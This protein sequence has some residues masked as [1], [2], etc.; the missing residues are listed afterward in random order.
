M[1]ETPLAVANSILERAELEG[2]R[3]THLQLQKLVYFVYKRLLQN[4]GEVLFSDFFEAWTWGPVVRKVYDCFKEYGDRNIDGY[5]YI[6]G[7]SSVFVISK[8]DIEFYDALNWVWDN[9]RSHTAP[10]LVSLTHVKGGAW[11]TAKTEGVL[12]IDDE[13]IKREGWLFSVAR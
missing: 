9:Y 8:E 2:K 3:I 4:T 13:N 10:E 5:A 11:D 1:L 7:E 12:E 6:D